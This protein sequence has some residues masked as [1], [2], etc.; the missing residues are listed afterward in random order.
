M[1]KPPPKFTLACLIVTTTS[2]FSRSPP[3][4]PGP[5]PEVKNFADSLSVVSCERRADFDG[6]TFTVQNISDRP[7]GYIAISAFE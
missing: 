3:E 2:L 1:H 6:W 4:S 5:A 7:L